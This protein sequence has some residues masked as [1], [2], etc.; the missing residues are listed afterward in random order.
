MSQCRAWLSGHGVA[1]LA[2]GFDALLWRLPG[3]ATSEPAASDRILASGDR[4]EGNGWALGG[5]GWWPADAAFA[6][7]GCL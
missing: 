6:W 5:G 3:M 4:C 7:P 2:D 1:A